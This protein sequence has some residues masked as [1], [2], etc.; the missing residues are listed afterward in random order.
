MTSEA[1]NRCQLLHFSLSL[2]YASA[3]HE[4]QPLVP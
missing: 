4:N 2:R 3:K 1:E